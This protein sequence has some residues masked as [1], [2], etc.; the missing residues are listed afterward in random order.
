MNYYSNGDEVELNDIVRVCKQK[1]LFN[2][3]GRIIVISGGMIGIDFGHEINDED[4]ELD[5]HHLSGRLPESTG[6]WVYY[7]NIEKVKNG[8]VVELL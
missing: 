5:T 2:E 4:G 3:V 1:D 8:L 7:K 6:R